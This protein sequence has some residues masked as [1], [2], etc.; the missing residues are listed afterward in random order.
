MRAM[1]SSLRHLPGV[2][3]HP[4]HAAH[5]MLVLRFLRGAC[6]GKR[7]VRCAVLEVPVSV[8]RDIDAVVGGDFV[9]GS[10]KEEA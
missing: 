1:R 4:L 5:S 6:D 8:G 3:I 10:G 2:H 9:N 7:R